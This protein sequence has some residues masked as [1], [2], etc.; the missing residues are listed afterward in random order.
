MENQ[1]TNNE[2]QNLQK[3]SQN[4][5]AKLQPFY[6]TKAIDLIKN[7]QPVYAQ[8]KKEKGNNIVFES[9]SII[10]EKFCYSMNVSKNM[11]KEQREE[12][13]ELIYQ[14]YWHW[15]PSHLTM[16][17]T[18]FK[19]HKYPEIELFQCIDIIIIFKILD[20]FDLELIRAKEK[21]E[22]EQMMLKRLEWEKESVPMPKEIKDA[23]GKIGKI[24]KEK[25]SMA[26]EPE[27]WN[28]TK[29]WISEFEIIYRMNPSQKGIRMIEIEGK[30]MDLTEYLQYK[31]NNEIEK[32]TNKEK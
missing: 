31:L 26:K 9:I 3:V 32:L 10:L 19:M 5:N 28:L 23:I 6:P 17:F 20:R 1:I 21:H 8:I 14:K 24:G 16:A 25:I 30:I 12:C 7:P 27:H 18:N 15:S 11:D 4:E 2:N 13:A 29:E 22:Q